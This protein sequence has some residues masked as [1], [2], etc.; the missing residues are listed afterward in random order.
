[1]VPAAMAVLKGNLRP[2]FDLTLI[3]LGVTSFQ[4]FS[5]PKNLPTIS[6]MFRSRTPNNFAS[7]SP[8]LPSTEPTHKL[9][10]SKDLK[11][12]LEGRPQK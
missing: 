6:S 3:N 11:V 2:P 9:V 7:S 5:A 4:D 12:S 8:K 10:V 1:M